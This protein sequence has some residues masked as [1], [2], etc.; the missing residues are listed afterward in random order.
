MTPKMIEMDPGAD[1]DFSTW[2][3]FGFEVTLHV[4]FGHLWVK[5]DGT[6]T[7]DQLQE[8]KAQAWGE[9][10]R[11]IE[12]YP[13]H[14]QLVDK[15]NIRHLWRLGAHD[16][17]PDLLGREGHGDSLVSRYARAWAKARS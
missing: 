16:F 17:A 8:I 9:D 5:H 12:V 13:A 6:I 10:A 3:S 11:A 4:P 2:V 15:G 14:A 7:W 1:A